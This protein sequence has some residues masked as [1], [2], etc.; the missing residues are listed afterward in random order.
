MVLRT[1]LKATAAALHR[2]GTGVTVLIYHRVGGGTDNA[3]DLAVEVF[4]AQIAE[5]ADRVI[6]LDTAVASLEAGATA[7]QATSPDGAVVIT[8]DDGTAD[9]VDHALPV[10]AAHRVP[11]TLYAATAFIDEGRAWPG[12][13]APVSWAG[14]AEACS[15][16]LVTVGSH[17]HTH[18][19]L[20]RAPEAVVAD[21]LDRS[22]GLIEDRLGQPAE[23]FAYPKA[24][25][26]SAAAD[27]LVRNRFRSAAVAGTRANGI[28]ADPYRLARSP[29]QR[30]D[31][32][33]WFRVKAAGGMRLEDDVRRLV[34]RV[35]YRRATT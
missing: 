11:A 21:E 17:T 7:D 14:L 9:F 32:M 6:S 28:D 2:R 23:H 25:A 3:V 12:D 10:L 4:N 5:L 31:E 19:L 26:G 29:I 16:G 33:R 22:R 27:R 34:N 24:V 20:D 13:V 30:G 15:T 18:R 8:F 35:R 1:A